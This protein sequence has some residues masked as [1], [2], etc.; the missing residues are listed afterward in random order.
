[1]GDS[2]KR[3]TCKDKHLGTYL[4]DSAILDHQYPRLAIHSN[5]FLPVCNFPANKETTR[6]KKIMTGDVMFNNDK[7]KKKNRKRRTF[8]DLS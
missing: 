7:N 2:R 4:D 1:M 3:S 6:P 8:T 5:E